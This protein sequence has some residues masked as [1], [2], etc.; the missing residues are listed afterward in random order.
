MRGAEAFDPCGLCAKP[1]LGHLRWP[2]A[3]AVA[4]SVRPAEP[5]GWTG[6]EGAGVFQEAG[7][8]GKG[9]DSVLEES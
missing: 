1:R 7:S 8:P 2:G 9:Q 3:E 4:P 6:R 5:S